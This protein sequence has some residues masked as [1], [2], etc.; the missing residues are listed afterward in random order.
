MATGLDLFITFYPHI[1]SACY[2]EWRILRKDE[3]IIVWWYW[4]CREEKYIERVDTRQVC[5]PL[6][7]ELRL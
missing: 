2:C 6:R 3:C 5:K 4:N 1:I 7:V